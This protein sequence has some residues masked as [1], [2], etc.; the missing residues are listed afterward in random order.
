VSC[1]DSLT[2]V[3]ELARCV[4]GIRV[5]PE[6]SCKPA[7]A[8]SFDEVRD[9]GESL[10]VAFTPKGL[11]LIQRGGG[12]KD[13]REAYCRRYGRLLEQAP[14]PDALRKQVVQAVRGEGGGKPRVDWDD[15]ITELERDVFAALVKI[16]RGEVRTYEWLARQSGHPRAV[17]AVGSVL[18]KNRVPLVVPCHRVVPSSGGVG[19]YIFG[20]SM[21]RELLQREGVDV[22]GLDDLARQ[23]VRFIG[24]RTT[25][26]ACFPTCGDAMRIRAENRVPFRDARQAEEKGFRPCMKCQPWAA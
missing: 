10:W 11:R 12:E 8:D 25:K 15:E 19:Q 7:L 2:D 4:S 24:S 23:G 1:K 14:I 21:K 22:E 17:R 18:A 6:K 5:K 13:L 20:S 9:G 3:D 16:P 26:I